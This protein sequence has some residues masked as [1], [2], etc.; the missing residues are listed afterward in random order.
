MKLKKSLEKYID[1][2]KYEKNLSLNTIES[3]ENDVLQLI[4][5]LNRLNI[6]ETEKL[7]LEDFRKFLKFIDNFNYAKSSLIRK[8]SSFLNFFKFLE[9]SGYINKSLSQHIRVPKKD[10]KFFTI[11]SR[12][13]MLALL[14]SITPDSDTGKRD[15]AIIEVIYSTG[16]RVSEVENIKVGDIN[17]TAREIKVIGKGNKQRAVYLNSQSIECLDSYLAVRGNFLSF[18]NGRKEN[19]YL[20]LNHK[21]GKLSSRSIRNIVKKYLKE[22]GIKKNI[23]PHSIRHSFASHLLQGGAGIREIQEL[24]GHEDISTTQI[25]THLNIKKLKQDYRNYH[26]RAK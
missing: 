16:A 17:F 9:E 7:N 13:E 6:S 3:Y 12:D 5:Y 18:K 8:Y 25:Y 19:R 15:R 10:K 11:L 1:F 24:L 20:F 21:G 23:T 26:P 2:L 22:A 4:N 14:D